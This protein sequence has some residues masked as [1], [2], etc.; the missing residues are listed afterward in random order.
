MEQ[1]LMSKNTITNYLW[2]CLLSSLVSIFPVLFCYSNQS[3]TFGQT[4]FNLFDPDHAK[5]FN[6]SKL[7]VSF[8]FMI[9][10]IQIFKL[11]F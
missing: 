2:E 3:S 10:V 4:I 8:Y 6:I 5:N 9:P 7:V 11:E 1:L